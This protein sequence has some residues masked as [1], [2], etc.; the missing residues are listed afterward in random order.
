VVW[1]AINSGRDGS[2]GDLDNA[3]AS[4]WLQ[5]KNAAPAAYVRDQDGK[6]GR[7]YGAKT[8]PHLYVINGG[9]TLVYNGAI[10][11][12]RSA[13]IDDIAKAENYVTS[14][15]AAVKSGRPVAKS[16]SQPY[17]CAVKY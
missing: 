7:L 11:S 3:A 2:E 8:T 12:I 15:L 1:L 13:E 6:V 10:D 4:A 9:G 17:G 14:A 5:S 16:S